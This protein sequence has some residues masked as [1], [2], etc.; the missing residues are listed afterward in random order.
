MEH[1]NMEIE[2]INLKDDYFNFN[3]KSSGCYSSVRFSPD[4]NFAITG[5]SDHT[6]EVWD[7]NKRN[8]VRSLKR[9]T[10]LVTSAICSPDG[11][12]I[13][14]GAEDGIAIHW[15]FLTGDV[16]KIFQEDPE[17][18]YLFKKQRYDNEWDQ[19]IDSVQLGENISEVSVS[20]NGKYGLYGIN[21]PS[22]VSK[23][24]LCN[25]LNREIEKEFTF[26]KC[27]VYSIISY[28]NEKYAFFSCEEE[29]TIKLLDLINEEI[30]YEFRGHSGKIISLASSQDGKYLLSGS[31]DNTLRLWDL[32]TGET[33]IILSGHKS[34]IN[35]V[36]ISRDGKFALS[37]S[38]DQT[39][40]L[41]DIFNNKTIAIFGNNGQ[42][43]SVAFSPDGKY[44]LAGFN[45]R[46]DDSNLKLLDLTVLD[47][48]EALCNCS[49]DEKQINKLTFNNVIDSSL[50]KKTSNDISV[51]EHS[52]KIN[53]KQIIKI[54]AWLYTISLLMY[55]MC[56]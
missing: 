13:F 50:L 8:L 40:R 36:D 48:Y 37:G 33:K 18:L 42:V 46:E 43:Q 19:D 30:V 35:S 31:N 52:T 20:S 23:I 6:V 53:G 5:T 4:G 2:I 9:H 41:W 55:Y 22:L 3:D 14:S 56:K 45:N 25:L 26:N 54:L 34:Q 28:G 27:N 44:A 17:E 51:K 24:K 47:S 12:Y 16:I 7:I 38:A 32:S 1:Q 49:S 39:I 11:K 15:N 29:N 10:D 21:F